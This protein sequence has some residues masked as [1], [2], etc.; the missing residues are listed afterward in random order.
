[1]VQSLLPGGALRPPTFGAG[2]LV[3]HTDALLP[4]CLTWQG[5]AW[6]AIGSLFWGPGVRAVS[7]AGSPEAVDLGLSTAVFS[8]SPHVFFLLPERA[9]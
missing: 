9:S 3:P 5:D 8:P 1:M 7:G 6:T 4:W 2:H